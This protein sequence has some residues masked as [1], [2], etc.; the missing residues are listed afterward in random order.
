MQHSGHKERARR[1]FLS[2]TG[3]SRSRIAAQT[4]QG[5]NEEAHPVA[6]ATLR[7]P[8]LP[9][10]LIPRPALAE[11][12]E[13]ALSAPLTVLSAPAG[14][15]KTT[16]LS[17]WAAACDRP[18]AWVS[19]ESSW[20]VKSLVRAVVDAVRVESSASCRATLGLLR[21]ARLPDPRYLGV[22]LAADLDEMSGGIVIVLDDYQAIDD[23]HVHDLVAAL[24]SHTPTAV[25]LVVATRRELPVPLAA[26]R[27]RGLV[28]TI[29]ATHLR[30]S[31]DEA[32]SF[33]RAVLGTSPDEEMVAD[34]TSRTEGWPAGLRLA[35][36]ALESQADHSV[37]VQAFTRG[38]HPYVRDFLIDDVLATQPEHIQGVLLQ[39]SILDR[40]CAEELEAVLRLN[41]DVRGEAILHQLIRSNLFVDQLGADGKW[42]RYHQLFQEALQE[43]LSRT[44]PTEVVSDLHARAAGWL[45]TQGLTDEAIH[46]YLAAGL[47]EDAGKLVD[48][49]MHPALNQPLD[50]RAGLTWREQE[51]LELLGERLSN[52]EIATRLGLSPLTVKRHTISLYRKLEVQ[53]RREAVARATVLRLLPSHIG[54][55]RVT[56]FA[57]PSAARL[58]LL[59]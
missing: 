12:L 9:R 22:T 53:G 58:A 50:L 48:A 13:R 26:L 35:A 46:H 47:R 51:V 56:G 36:L 45:A 41:R 37:W 39:S 15:G 34:L 43:K 19:L 44:S 17:T 29:G 23:P 11:R 55:D 10:D 8:T 6:R 25:R 21:L 52:K 42:F 59:A 20:S 16:L 38:S 57:V 4:H 18:L 54:P 30:F 3:A 32:R 31:M 49:P 33:L 2:P 14:F 1:R 7:P 40:F 27:A 28:S 5:L 24:L